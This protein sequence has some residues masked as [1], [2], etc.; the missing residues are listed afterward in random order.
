MRPECAKD[1]EVVLSV[2][3]E[4]FKLT[5]DDGQSKVLR[6]IVDDCVFLG[7]NTHYFITLESGVK[8]EI[9]QESSIDNDIKAGTK[10]M[11][12]MNAEKVNVFTADGSENILTG[13][14]ND[15]IK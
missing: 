11:L 15:C 13:V 12:T 10:I 5:A 3:P 7:L 9:I 14:R 6:G 2:R 1:Q 8:V 4:E